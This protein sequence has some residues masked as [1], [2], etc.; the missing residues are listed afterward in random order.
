MAQGPVIRL[1]VFGNPVAQ[2]LSPVIHRA[3][4]QQCGL[5]VDYRA[6][7]ATRESF[8]DQVV[9]LARHGGRGCNITAPFKH[10]ALKLAHHSSESADRAQAANTLVFEEGGEWFA[11][12]T[13]GM[14][15]INDLNAGAAAKLKGARICLLGAGGAAASVLAALVASGPETV[16]IANRSLDRAR[17]LAS[18]HSDLG[19]V[20]SCTPGELFNQAPFDLF[21]NATSLGHSGSAPRLSGEWLKPDALC[22]DMNYGAAALPLRDACSEL[23]FRY[24]DGLGMLV[25]QAALSFELWTGKVPDAAKVLLQLRSSPG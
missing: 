12:S 22:Y 7:E 6:I 18:T 15:L 3:F 8:T 14:G 25:G 2:S 5:S 17:S 23:G 9:L 21:I 10:D 4:A 1:A 11:D 20:E 13:D 19:P 24:S 16:I